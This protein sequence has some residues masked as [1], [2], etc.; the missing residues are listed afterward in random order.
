MIKKCTEF[1]RGRGCLQIEFSVFCAF[2]DTD[3]AV[4]R[5]AL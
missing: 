4:C 3:A 1:Q 2:L 5:V